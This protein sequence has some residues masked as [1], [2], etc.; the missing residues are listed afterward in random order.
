MQISAT[1]KHKTFYRTVSYDG[2]TEDASGAGETAWW[3]RK[4]IVPAED[5][6]A[7]GASQP[8]GSSRASNDLLRH[9]T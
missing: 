4:F 1:V 7:L 8:S 2:F 6:G 9:Q 3:L 5:P